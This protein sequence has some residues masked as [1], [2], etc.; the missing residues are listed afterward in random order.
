MSVLIFGIIIEDFKSES[1][2]GLIEKAFGKEANKYIEGLLQDLNGGVKPPRGEGLYNQLLSLFKKSAVYAS[3]SVAIQQPSSI[4]RAFAVVDPKYFAKTIFQ[5]RDY[6]ELKKYSAQAVLKEWGFFDTHLGRDITDLLIQPEPE[7]VTERIKRLMKDKEYRKNYLDEIFSW[8]PQKMDEITWTHIWNAVKAEIADKRPEL[9]VGSQEFFEA[10]AERF[11][12]VIDR[13]Q[14]MDSVFQRAEIM[15]SPSAA[16]KT[17]TLFMAEPLTSLNM[18]IDAGLEKNKGSRARIVSSVIASMVLN[19]ALA[20]I[21]YA[22]RDDDEDKIY[23]EKYFEA[24]IDELIDAPTSMI[25]YVKD[26]VS[27]IKGYTP[28]RP[29][30][31]LVYD[32]YTRFKRVGNDKYSAFEQA[33]GVLEGLAAFAGIPLKNIHRD[34]EAIYDTTVQMINFGISGDQKKD[35][36]LAFEIAKNKYDIN[37][38]DKDGSL[39]SAVSAVFYDI[40]FAAK[41]KGDMATYEAVRRYMLNS[42]R[43]ASAFEE[44]MLNRAVKQLVGDV[45]KK[46]KGDPRIKEAAQAQ[47]DGDYPKRLRIINELIAEG[48]DKKVVLKA[49]EEVVSQLYKENAPTPEEFIEAYKTGDRSKWY[50]LYKRLKLAGWSDKDILALVK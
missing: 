28:K 5:Q 48:H 43:K 32:L 34:I 21:V 24:F 6:E 18:L 13:T 41:Q 40:A 26:V 9:K 50:P 31:Q 12:E 33:K 30:L 44:A 29:D 46:I 14:V 19:A 11:K 2:R 45:K 35:P 8:L 7:S 47:F 20:A 17:A 3:L 37:K 25:P 49:V 4:A 1:V 15:R 36:A 38:R 10:A 42:G 39:N 22:M 23:S 16:M 27:I